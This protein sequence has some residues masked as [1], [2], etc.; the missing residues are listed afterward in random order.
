MV[1]AGLIGSVET[2]TFPQFTTSKITTSTT[3]L[4]TFCPRFCNQ[5]TTIPALEI[6]KISPQ[7]PNPI[8][9]NTETHHNSPQMPKS[10]FIHRQMVRPQL[11][12]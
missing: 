1:F 8:P 11:L 9:G 4:T 5:K 7:K 10:S 3:Q 2:K 12:T 6:Q